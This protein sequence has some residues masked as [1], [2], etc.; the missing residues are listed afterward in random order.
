MKQILEFIPLVLF[1]A[2]YK[3]YDIYAGTAVLMAS[4]TIFLPITYLIYKKIEKVQIFTYLAIIAFGTMTLV[5]HN[6]DFLIWKVSIVYFIF[7]GGLLISQYLFNNNLMQK[8]LG[9]E[10]SLPQMVWDRIN[11]GWAFFFLSCALLNLYIGF[12]MPE[13]T[14]VNFKV[15]GMMALTLSFTLITGIYLYRHLPKEEKQQ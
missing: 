6:K 11:L 4:A 12:T 14:W 3:M 1:F 15:F 13:A 9:K 10:L 8:V 7:T 2:V 5:F